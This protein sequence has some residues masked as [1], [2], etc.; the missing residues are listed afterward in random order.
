MDLY[1][2][3]GLT[4]D[5]S[6]DAVERAYRRLSRRY[7]PGV[8]PGDRVAEELYDQIQQAYQVLADPVGRGEYDRGANRAPGVSVEATVSFDGFD[9]SAPAHGP[10]AATFSELFADVFQAAAREATTPSRGSDVE[11]RVRVA[12]E[13][14]V[15]GGPVPLSIT[16]QERCAACAGDGRIARPPVVCPGCRGAGERRWARGHMVFTKP[17]ESCGGAGRIVTATCRACSGVGSAAQSAVVTLTIPPGLESGARVA[18]PGR[19]HVG[20]RGGPAGDLYVT[21][22]VAEHPF[23]R[24]MGQDVHLT[25]PLAVH[26]A[27]LGTKVEVPTLDGTAK[28]RIPPGTSSGQRIRVPGGGV[29]ASRDGA[30]GDLVAEIQ[31]VLP[32]VADARSRELMKEFGRLNDAN[33]RAHFWGG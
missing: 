32:P 19:G 6:P 14:A 8:N 24:R 23:F 17:C 12:F 3:L 16:R 33:V 18:V 10:T 22:E 30:V 11:A 27:A 4:R 5:A 15:R 1:S 25:L 9:F 7:H 20:A 13:H 2:L 21:I 28:L 31:I 29:P 26:E